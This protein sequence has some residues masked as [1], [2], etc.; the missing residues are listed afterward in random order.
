MEGLDEDEDDKDSDLDSELIE[1]EQD[2]MEKQK[3]IRER[4]K[5]VKG[6]KVPKRL[7]GDTATEKFMEEVRP[8]F[9]EKTKDVKL[10]STKMRREQKDKLRSQLKQE[11]GVTEEDE[12]IDEDAMDIDED[13]PSKKKK[14]SP[15]EE[16]K[17]KVDK[18]KQKTIERMQRKIQ[19]KWN[20]DA[21]VNEADAPSFSPHQA[22]PSPADEPWWLAGRRY[23][24]CT[25]PPRRTSHNPSGIS[26]P[27][28][29]RCPTPYLSAHV[30]RWISP[31]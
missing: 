1:A 6:A 12:A 16:L 18:Q 28:A 8:D 14:L 23:G 5:L 13:A 2:V 25:W 22:R 29:R 9:K 7:T 27:P 21:R 4:H 15:E 10:L 20:R 26:P 30:P 3:M 24:S 17:L 19:K 11:A 31:P